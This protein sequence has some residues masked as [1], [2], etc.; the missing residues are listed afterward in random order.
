MYIVSKQLKID[1][2]DVNFHGSIDCQRIIL[3]FW[4]TFP[5]ANAYEIWELI[6][7]SHI[8]LNM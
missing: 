2:F 3:D 5:Y 1:D 4:L 8:L 7:S 6:I